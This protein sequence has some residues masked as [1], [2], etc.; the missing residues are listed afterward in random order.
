MS[1]QT[2]PVGPA[3]GHQDA[4][5]FAGTGTRV[6]LDHTALDQLLTSTDGPVA[7]MLLRDTIRIEADAKRRTP[8]DTGRL[9]ASI[10]RAIEHDAQG[11]VGIVGTNVEYAPYVELGT[12]RMR[13]RP[14]LR[15]AL[16]A[17]SETT[18]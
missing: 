13:A 16:G 8:V 17:A 3:Q 12:R 1:D 10:T 15:P 5:H 14:F 9:R 4:A 18:R 11:L 2:P 6:V 7:K